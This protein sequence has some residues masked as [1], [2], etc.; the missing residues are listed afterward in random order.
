[1]KK[2]PPCR[3]IATLPPYVGHRALVIGHPAID[4]LR[5]NTVSPLAESRRDILAR[6]KDECGG[7]RLWIDLKG[8]QLRI[9]KF[10]YLPHAFVELNHRISVDLPAE[11]RFRDCLS[12]IVKIVDGRKLILDQR[13]VRIVGEGEPVNILD[14]SL[15]IEGYLTE[16]DREYVEAAVGLGLHDFMLS[17]AENDEDAAE[18]RRLDS[19]A[20]LVA[21]IESKRGLAWMRD[22][23]AD[24]GLMA[25]RDD[26]YVN[27]GEDRSAIL[28]AL[29]AV[30]AADRQAMVASRLLESLEAGPAPSLPD[31]SDVALM[32]EMGYRTFMFSD[33]LCFREG[34]F[35]AAAACMAA[36]LGKK[37]DG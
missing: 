12:T 37:G 24:V 17:F 21:K 32:R 2:P 33:T 35:R 27:M 16:S 13:P 1:M 15:R 10:A 11:I 25:A 22:R 36:L 6:L 29:R 19:K 30:V 4:A 20:R 23:P 14:P 34:S 18:V 7:K 31:L 28:D 8:R 9:A 5:F 26:L 3:L